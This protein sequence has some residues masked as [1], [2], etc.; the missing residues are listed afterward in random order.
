MLLHYWFRLWTANS[1]V[2]AYLVK[3][4]DQDLDCASIVLNCQCHPAVCDCVQGR[5]R[6]RQPVAASHYQW[7]CPVPTIGCYVFCPANHNGHKLT[8]KLIR[9]KTECKEATS[10]LHMHPH[11]YT[12]IRNKTGHYYFFQL[13]LSH[14]LL[15]ALAVLMPKLGN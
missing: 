2:A 15:E 5:R 13:L 8:L 12:E 10:D 3:A 1:H 11:T 9:L 4:E 14:Q 7:L 6:E